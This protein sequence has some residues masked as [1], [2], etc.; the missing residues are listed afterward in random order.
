MTDVRDRLRGLYVITD[1]ALAGGRALPSLVEDALAGGARVV[2]YRDKTTDHA[3]RHAEAAALAALC[4]D[5]AALLIVNDDVELA[6]A[7]HA[8]GVHLGRDD[9][10]I[11]AARARLGPD[12]VIGVS[13]YD[14]FEL[15]LAAQE[16]GADYVAFGSFHPSPTKPAAVRADLSLLARGRRELTLPL[17]AIGGITPENG[18]ALVV[19]GADM[20]AVI[21]A[22][23]GAADVR[24]AAA[25][26]AP[27]FASEEPPP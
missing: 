14:R 7:V 15:A 21:N 18:R 3:R 1:R 25:A 22:V 26:F 23:F 24:A 2:Q 17:V 9:D 13:C 12:R 8:D 5:A 11:A 20:L 4:R 27:L 16:A 19:A 10:A 6:L